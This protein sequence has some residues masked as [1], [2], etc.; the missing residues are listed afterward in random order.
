MI[1][2]E[3]E[4]RF[5]KQADEDYKALQETVIKDIENGLNNSFN[6]QLLK[7]ID[8]TKDNL[9]INPHYGDHI[10]RKIISKA[11]VKKYGTDRLYRSELV[12]F[13]RLI[14][15]IVGDEIKIIAFVLDFVDHKKYNKLFGYKKK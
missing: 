15:T 6:A 3:I 7:A 8:R 2:K 1:K 14:Y 11:L 12:G 13:W 9:K 4:V 10:S 5:S